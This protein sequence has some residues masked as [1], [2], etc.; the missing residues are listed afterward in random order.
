MTWSP[1]VE[2]AIAADAGRLRAPGSGS[3]G[4]LHS[5]SRPGHSWGSSRPSALSRSHLTRLITLF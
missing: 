2:A 4:S 1:R 5:A 3:S